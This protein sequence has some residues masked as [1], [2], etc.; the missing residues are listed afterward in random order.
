MEDTLTR[1][2][3]FLDLMAEQGKTWPTRPGSCVMVADAAGW[4]R[5]GIRDL[6]NSLLVPRSPEEIQ[7]RTRELL[8]DERDPASRSE[9]DPEEIPAGK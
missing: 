4:H 5:D 3:V 9:T 7:A 6:L 2:L 1:A 8:G